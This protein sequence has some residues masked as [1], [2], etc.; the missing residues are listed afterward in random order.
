M[1]FGDTPPAPRWTTD[2]DTALF[3]A[4]TAGHSAEIA[5]LVGRSVGA[6]TRR[7]RK[8]HRTTVR[9]IV[10]RTDGMSIQDVADA[11]GVPRAS[12]FH[13][14]HQGHI[15]V[16]TIGVFRTRM[17]TIAPLAVN[18][19]LL[20]GGAFRYLHPSEKWAPIVDQARSELARIYISPSEIAHLLGIQRS[21]L[22]WWRRRHAF[23]L[24]VRLAT[25]SSAQRFYYRADVA[26]WLEIHPEHCTT[27]WKSHMASLVGDQLAGGG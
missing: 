11:L 13:W 9:T 24:P 16:R 22:Q 10:R 2:E 6:A 7:L 15:Q 26:L 20:F 18:T 14:I 1:P 4:I 8:I 12:V 25:V 3:D 23:P 5:A 19:F 27:T 17:Y 21:L